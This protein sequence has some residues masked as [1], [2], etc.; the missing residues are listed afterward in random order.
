MKYKKDTHHPLEV[1][2]IFD[3]HKLMILQNYLVSF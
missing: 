1:F 2:R 3:I